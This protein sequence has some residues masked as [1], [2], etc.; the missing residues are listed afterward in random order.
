MF[1]RIRKYWRNWPA[2]SDFD[3]QTYRKDCLAR[4]RRQWSADRKSHS[5]YESEAR[6]LR[7][8]HEAAVITAIRPIRGNT[9][10]PQYCTKLASY[11]MIILLH[12][13]TIESLWYCH[14]C[15]TSEF[16]SV[17]RTDSIMTNRV[18]SYSV[19]RSRLVSWPQTLPISRI[20]FK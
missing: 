9:V 11:T 14:T 16:F 7:P 12:G 4:S 15:T 17:S 8:R 19:S 10:S 5:V 13:N 6:G 1:K 20:R 2:N 18:R 3:L